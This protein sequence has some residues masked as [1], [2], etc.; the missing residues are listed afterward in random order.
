MKPVFRNSL[1]AI[2]LVAAASSS[3]K[4]FTD[5]NYYRW[6]DSRGHPVHSDRPP[7]A[8]INYEVVST[9]STFTRVVPAE[10]GA[11]PPEVKP[12]VGNEFTP[13]DTTDAERSKKNSELC[14]RARSNLEA[15]TASDTV[16]IRN[17]EGEVQQL[18]LQEIQIQ[19]ETTQAQINV[20]CE[21]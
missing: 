7:P 2:L 8:G 11:V 19:R 1:H 15:L 17:S 13:V 9:E 20:Y 6:L 18:N 10:E 4:G 14:Q 5:T 21:S 16:N 12:T 3:I